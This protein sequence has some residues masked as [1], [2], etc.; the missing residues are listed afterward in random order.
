[1]EEKTPR[2][3]GKKRK[4]TIEQQRIETPDRKDR[5]RK[6]NSKSRETI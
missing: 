5:E 4:Y 3:R 1:M 2:K 6:R